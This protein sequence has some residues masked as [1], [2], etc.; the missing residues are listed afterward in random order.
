MSLDI[1]V[2]KHKRII[3]RKKLVIWDALCDLQFMFGHRPQ[4]PLPTIFKL[5]QPD[6]SGTFS[7]ERLQLLLDG[8]IIYRDKN[9][10]EE[11]KTLSR[12]EI[13][14]KGILGG[15]HIVTIEERDTLN[16]L[17]KVVEDNLGKLDTRI[18][19]VCH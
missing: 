10:S 12:F 7:Q 13:Q 5:L 16:R 17:I 8:L 3:W 6:G 19:F 2:A 4:F 15:L 14:R 11:Q 1:Y 9:Y 18:I